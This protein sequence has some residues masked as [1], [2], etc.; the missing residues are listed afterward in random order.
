MNNQRHLSV[1]VTALAMKA[2]ITPPLSVA[3]ST[4][5]RNIIYSRR[6]LEGGVY[7]TIWTCRAELCGESGYVVPLE[8]R[9]SREG[10]RA[11]LWS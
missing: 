1:K 11:S 2:T 10:D 4:D 9:L 6:N 5:R 8:S 7:E 3:G